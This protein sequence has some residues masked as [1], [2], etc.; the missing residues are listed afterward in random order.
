MPE[1]NGGPKAPIRIG[2]WWFH[3]ELNRLR[4]GNSVIHLE[5]KAALALMLLVERA[6][7]P[8]TRQE[9]LDSVWKDVVVSDDALTQ[10]I[11]KLRKA[12]GDSSRD[13]RYIKT[14]P[15]RGYCLLAD[16]QTGTGSAD[17]LNEQPRQ[18]LP[19]TNRYLVPGMAILAIVLAAS[20][21]GYL[22]IDD[23][24]PAYR[25][26]V[27]VTVAEGATLTI[28]P[29]EA[30]SENER[31]RRFARG[32]RADLITDLSGLPELTVINPSISKA[33]P[34]AARYQVYGNVQQ[35][36]ELISVHIRLVE[37]ASQRQL[38][39]RRYERALDDIFQVQHSISRDVVDQLTLEVP[40]ANLERLASRYTP[41]LLAY[42]NFLRGQA[43]L[44]LREREANT[45]A[46]HWYR[47]AIQHDP[48]FARAF[49]GLALSYAA[50]FRN[51]WTDDGEKALRQ[52]Q[53]MAQT[54]AQI[55]PEIAEV[56]WVLG[57]VTAQFKQHEEALAHL[58]RALEVDHSY[59]DAYALM[60]G[61]NTYLGRP[62]F[63]IGQ[64]RSALRLNQNAGYLYYLI[65]GRAYY[66]MG[67]YEQALINLNE[68]LARNPTNLETHIYL[69]ATAVAQ[70]DT[71]T[72]DWE[73][74]EIRIIE[75]GFEGNRWLETY[76][77]TD[78]DQRKML[79][80]VLAR[81]ES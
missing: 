54:G 28:M 12:L 18:G 22:F 37:T 45:T 69:L 71:D 39:S 41:N 40:A 25:G 79:A 59:A 1:L 51:H 7:V 14:I 16:V 65:L 21:L 9:L 15:K 43:D 6:G 60:G 76:P 8:V 70:Q 48:N 26:P 33:V 80:D 74:E 30:I 46:R 31:E 29:F 66:F 5:P 20:M 81:V 34:V 3:P 13:P 36:G 55:D 67:K 24:S 75:P 72:A 61:I 56:Y 32:M 42:E 58:Q 68:S 4:D 53:E 27:E 64:L 17:T 73:I 19:G 50:D 35:V 44:L 49:A 78:E 10:V 38:W 52:A 77:M 57:Y 11:I 63:T 2:S 47:Q 23:P 62:D